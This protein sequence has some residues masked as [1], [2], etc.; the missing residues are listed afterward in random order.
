MS[1]NNSRIKN[2]DLGIESASNKI[3][4]VYKYDKIRDFNFLF[5]PDQNIS[6]RYCRSD[7]IV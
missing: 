7:K 4:I 1:T 3:S 6:I 5:I 2:A